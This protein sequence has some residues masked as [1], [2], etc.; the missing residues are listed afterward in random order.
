VFAGRLRKAE[1]LARHRAAD[2]FLDTHGCCAHTTASDALWAGLPVLACPGEGFASRVSASLLHAVGLG[3]LVCAS[4]EEY[5]RRAIALATGGGLDAL[6]ARLAHNR[7]R[8][9]LFDTARF[10]RH[11]EAAYLALADRGAARAA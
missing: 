3:E 8:L 1:H 10:T 4:A 11:L 7:T 6:R 9:P 5:E 2:L